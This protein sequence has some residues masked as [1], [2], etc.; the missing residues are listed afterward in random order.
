[1]PNSRVLFGRGRTPAALAIILTMVFAACEEETAPGPAPVDI[2]IVSG[3]DQYSKVGTEL[4][5]PIVAQ[6]TLAD[7]A[8]GAGVPVRFVVRSGGGSLSRST[9]TTNAQ[10]E[11]SVRWTL[12]PTLGTQQLTIEIDGDG[13]VETVAQATAAE[14]HCPEEDPAFLQRF[15]PVNNLFVF[16]RR[17]SVVAGSGPQRA[18]V[19]Q[20]GMDLTDLEFSA[21]AFVGFDDTGFIGVVKDCA[22]SANGEFYISWLNTQGRSEIAK[23]NPNKSIE[24]F[25]TL[26]STVGSE[27]TAIEGGVLGG[28]D[29][30]GPFTVGCRD[31]LT[32]YDDAIFAGTGADQANSDAVAYDPAGDHLYFIDRTM[33][34]LRRVPLDGYEQT[35]DTE[36]VAVLTI[37]EANDAKG[38]VYHNGSIYILVESDDTKAIVAVTTAGT[39]TT[40]FDFFTRG[41][42]DAAGIQNDIALFVQGALVAFYTVDTLNDVVLLCQLAPSTGIFEIGPDGSTD[43]EAVSTEASSGE[44]LGVALLPAS[45][46][47]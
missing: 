30:F 37:D 5:A 14:F 46:P 20:L 35:G 19:V 25:A 9:A 16:T 36:E 47:F 39:K 28:C 44:R 17:S 4:E 1:M 22:F 45:A 3:D 21:A 26:E 41:S 29:E 8:V 2:E 12:G 11:T 40:A 31:T 10:G 18:G 42:G 32:R 34:R 38:M 7:G 24:H 6:V 13:E 33:R 27:I 43:S 23:I 15:T